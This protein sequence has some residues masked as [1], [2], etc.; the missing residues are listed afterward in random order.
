[1]ELLKFIILLCVLRVGQFQNLPESEQ[2]TNL[3][4]L[5]QEIYQGWIQSDAEAQNFLYYQL[6]SADGTSFNS[7]DASEIPLVLYLEGGPG[8]SSMLTVWTDFGPYGVSS[9]LNITEK[10]NIEDAEF[11]VYKRNLTWSQAYHILAIDSP[12]FSGFSFSMTGQILNDTRAVG[13]NLVSFL[14]RFYQVYSQLLS[15]PL[16]IVG[17]SYGG[18]WAP[19]FTYLL[20]NNNSLT[21]GNDERLNLKGL[22][23]LTPLTSVKLQTGLANYFFGAGVTDSNKRDIL[24]EFEAAIAE[25]Y[26][27]NQVLN[28]SLALDAA[29]SDIVN[30]GSTT[31]SSAF[32]R[33]NIRQDQVPGSIYSYQ[34]LAH[35]KSTQ[36]FF[37]ITGSISGRA[38]LNIPANISFLEGYCTN[39]FMESADLGMDLSYTI[40][41]L[42]DQNLPVTVL[43]GQDD[44]T[45]PATGIVNLVGALNWTGAQ[46]FKNSARNT[47][48]ASNQTVLGTFKK[49][50]NLN[51][52]ILYK[53]GHLVTCDQPEAMYEFINKT[54]ANKW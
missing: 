42:L 19:Y 47:W 21:L 28:A 11:T 18:H 38:L 4:N 44:S 53:S 49:Y 3:P 36:T 29:S 5:T 54:I 45:I 20:V 40:E 2:I 13:A 7:S 51:M 34:T 9:N 41:Y 50:D 25:A 37:N 10:N 14:T 8:D 46:D 22:V 30:K 31:F 16:Y 35:F 23:L 26:E 43:A 52:V 15:N 27:Q 32:S 24:Q 17:H 33:F 39:E 48:Y 6:F 12:V 1:M